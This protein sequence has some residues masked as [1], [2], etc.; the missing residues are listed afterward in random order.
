[1]ILLRAVEL[2]DAREPVEVLSALRPIE[3]TLLPQ[4]VRLIAQGKLRAT[5]AVRGESSWSSPRPRD[6]RDRL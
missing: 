1:V 4:A 3:H 2:P 5:P 6:P